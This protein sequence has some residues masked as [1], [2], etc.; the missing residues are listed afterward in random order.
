MFDEL[1]R[2]FEM[3]FKRMKKEMEEMRRRFNKQMA[4]ALKDIKS[5]IRMPKMYTE[6]VGDKY[7]I[8]VELPG[9]RKEDV[10]IY[11][12]EK[13]MKINAEAKKMKE[14]IGKGIKKAQKTML[15]FKRIMSFPEKVKPETLKTKMKDGILEI[16]IKK[17]NPTI[18]KS[19]KKKKV[20][21]IKSK[22]KKSSSKK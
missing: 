2:D 22:R 14:I 18:A 8:R 21:K 7:I 12:S 4:S 1:L 10:M 16:T 9:V 19:S 3:E 20:A 13:S 17:K 5:G 11:L 6:D 15:N